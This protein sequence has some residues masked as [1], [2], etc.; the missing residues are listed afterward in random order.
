[1]LEDPLIGDSFIEPLKSQGVRRM[2]EFNMVIGLKYT[3]KPGE[4]F[5]IRKTVYQSVLA[6]FKE[7]G[8]QMASRNVK[9]DVPPD[10]TPEQKNEA[11]AAAAQQAS[12]Q[13]L[14]PKL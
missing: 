4:Q 3:S 10:A 5:T 9:V 8:I 1:M 11:T 2:E 13:Q 7:N 14:A 6:M 12:E